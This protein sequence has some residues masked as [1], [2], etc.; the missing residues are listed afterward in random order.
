MAGACGLFREN[1]G[2]DPLKVDTYFGSVR[3]TDAAP[4]AGAHASVW[5]LEASLH[6]GVDL[7][8]AHGLR[9]L[10]AATRRPRRA[11]AYIVAMNVVEQVWTRSSARG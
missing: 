6:R 1:V 5:D 4:N 11:F 2:P 8:A 7:L 3:S 10:P 9:R